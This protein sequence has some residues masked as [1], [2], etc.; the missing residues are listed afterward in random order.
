[1]HVQYKAW[2]QGPTLVFSEQYL[3]RYLKLFKSDASPKKV[4]K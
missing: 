2:D 1:M 3:Q 4:A